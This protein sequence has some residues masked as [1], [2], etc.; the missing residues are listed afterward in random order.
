MRLGILLPIT[1]RGLAPPPGAPASAAAS[2]IAER[3]SQL[4]G[5]MGGAAGADLVVLLGL[6]HDDTRLLAHQPLL[7]EP[8]RRALPDAEA[9]AVVFGAGAPGPAGAVC[10]LWARLAEVAAREHG[11]QLA[12]L[13]GDDV[14][15]SPQGWPA[16]VVARFAADPRLSLLLLQDQA[17]PG[18]PSFPVLRV[19]RHL[20]TFGELLPDCFVNQ[21]GDPFLAALYRCA[22][23]TLAEAR[24]ITVVN[25]QGGPQLAGHPY[26]PP[27]YARRPPLHAAVLRELQ[28]WR[29]RLLEPPPAGA[30]CDG[31]G[32]AAALDACGGAA[33]AVTTV[34]VL[35]PSYRVDAAILELMERRI[36]D[37][38]AADPSADVCLVLVL[39]SPAHAAAAAP[40]LLEL[41]RRMSRRLQL[42]ANS[43]NLGAPAARNRAL[44]ES[45]AEFAVFWDD[46]VEPDPGC[47][48]AYIDSFTRH[49]EA[50]A[51]AGPSR[52][53]HEPARLWPCAVHMSDVSFFWEAPAQ[54]G[55]ERGLV[56]WAVTAN[57]AVRRWAVGGAAFD[58][59]FPKTGGGEDID[60]CLR[61]AGA[62]RMVAVPQAGVQ[63]PWWNGG[64]RC[65]RRFYRWA[66]GDGDL[67][68]I[69]RGGLPAPVA[70]ADS[71]ESAAAPRG[72][73]GARRGGA[74]GA[75]RG[76]A[77]GGGAA[78]G[79][80]RARAVVPLVYR[81][82]PSAVEL[83]ALAC[84][85]AAA[86]IAAAAAAAPPLDAAA[87]AGAAGGRP[88][89]CA[90][91]VAAAA[92]LLAP[93][94]A[95]LAGLARATAAVL[96]TDLLLD[97]AR[98]LCCAER[99]ARCP[100]A[101][102]LRPV[103]ACEAW[104]IKAASEAGRLSGHLDRNGRLVGGWLAVGR[105]FDWFCGMDPRIV[106][107]E[108][109]RAA[110]WFAFFAAAAAWAAF[111]PLA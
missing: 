97:V 83:A 75:R 53:P 11:C 43:A 38:N 6:D 7:L 65:Y 104:A 52:L 94:A 44:E 70:G 30:G 58:L 55:A 12:V 102:L 8:W 86:L 69:W 10:R 39:D 84:Y 111:G 16:T 80:G 4:A 49:P 13:L 17:D 62:R 106:R 87:A 29:R 40:F 74:D 37:A 105:R 32:A 95:C 96:F 90:V 91:A 78:A 103:A 15:V 35:V 18:F 54:W 63:H 56:P 85:A 20:T 42:R 57:M 101:P 46:D 33:R 73:D 81:A 68:D 77:D 9:R 51:F 31:G 66:R 59:R 107:A 71:S 27:R 88:G 36:K 19:D 45:L 109:R 99:R 72:P 76:G 100:C 92:A 93:L 25:L 5:G 110:L 47:L 26:T 2:E 1:S 67:I 48:A 60:Y 61:V 14:R 82:A 108:R 41:Q 22:E 98:N 3:L 50:V 34:D 89:A 24:D 21:G 28:A 79:G 64:G 23:G